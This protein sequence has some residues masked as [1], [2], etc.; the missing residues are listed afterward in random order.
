MVEEKSD[1]EESSRRM[2]SDS[3]ATVCAARGKMLILMNISFYMYITDD[4]LSKYSL[5]SWVTRIRSVQQLR[6][7]GL[8]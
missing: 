8:M 2:N 5:P 4:R 7:E 6:D 3:K 1:S